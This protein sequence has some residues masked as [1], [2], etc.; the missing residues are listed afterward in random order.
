MYILKSKGFQK[1]LNYYHSRG[2]QYFT[3]RKTDDVLKHR[4]PKVQKKTHD[5]CLPNMGS[6]IRG[7]YGIKNI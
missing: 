3:S 7:K 4:H 6:E 5:V 1:S 2:N